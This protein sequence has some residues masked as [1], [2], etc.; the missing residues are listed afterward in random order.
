MIRVLLVSLAL[1]LS[2]PASPPPKAVLKAASAKAAQPVSYSS[3]S[4]SPSP[5]YDYEAEQELLEMANQVRA[6]RGAPRLQMDPGL[7]Q[8]ARAHAIA[9]AQQQQLSHQLSGEASLTQRLAATSDVRTDRAGENVALGVGVE[10]VQEHLL[11]SPA[12]RANLLNPDFNLAGLAV[13][14]LGAQLYVAQDFAHSMPSYSPDQTDSMVANA[15]EQLRTQL[16]L[17]ALVRVQDT[18]LR[19]TACTM[20]QQDALT[21]RETRTLA[22]R[23][24]LLTYTNT[25]PGDLPGSA[26]KLLNDRRLRNFAVGTCYARSSTY[27]SGVYWVVLLFY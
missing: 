1:L 13:V 19:N 24:N 2:T 11:Q 8:A 9:M 6:Q 20:A 22:Q 4:I 14:R 17:P 12:H 18:A 27:P 7:S 10:Q 5:T 26:G 16:T 25:R 3:S 15:V 23:Y 21:T